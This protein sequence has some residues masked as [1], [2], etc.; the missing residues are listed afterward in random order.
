M[1]TISDP[2]NYRK[3]SE[4]FES[5]DEANTALKQFMD[6]V[7]ELRQ[8]YRIAEVLTVVSVNVKYKDGEGK[9]IS[10]G[11]NGNY[12]EAESMAAYAYGDL[13]ANRRAY[14]NKL[15]KGGTREL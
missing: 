14:M 8:K 6:V 12:M 7:R 4:P 9:A 15:A 13:A 2:E 3:M 11:F 5:A 10:F 1:E